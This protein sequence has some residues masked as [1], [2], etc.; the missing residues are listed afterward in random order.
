MLALFDSGEK[1][2]AEKELD[3]A[4]QANP[5]NVI[6]L[7]GAAYWYAAHSEPDRAIELSQQAITAEPRY[8][9]S[10]LALAHAYFAK[11]QP[12]DAEQAL[13]RGR[14][15]GRFPTLEY[16]LALAR[17]KAGL[18]REAV[19]VLRGSFSVE[20][21]KVKVRLGGRVERADASFSELLAPE[22]KASIFEPESTTDPETAAILKALL[23]FDKEVQAPLANEAAIS[24][25]A[26]KFV[27]GDD[28]MKVHRQIYVATTLL[29][30]NVALPKVIELTKSAVDFTDQGLNAPNASAATMASELYDSRMLALSKNEYLHIP[31]V[32]KAMLSAIIRGRIEELAGWALY[33]E[34]QTADAVTRLRR[35]VSVLPP[36]SAWWRSSTWKLGAALQADGKDAESLQYYLKSYKADKPDAAR[37]IVVAAL[38]K[39]VKGNDEGLE[40]EIGPNP[41]AITAAVQF[42]PMSSPSPEAAPTP[43]PRIVSK[44]VRSAKTEVIPEVVPVATPTVE[45][46]TEETKTMTQ[47]TPSRDAA[48]PVVE[49]TTAP[50][51]ELTSEPAI[52]ST[53]EPKI[54]PAAI[55][56]P[57]ASPTPEISST[58]VP[59]EPAAAVPIPTP[60]AQ[61]SPTVM[62]EPTPSPKIEPDP[63]PPPM[64]E[65]SPT[66]STPEAIPSPTPAAEIPSAV[67]SPTPEPSLD[68]KPAEPPKQNPEE[69]KPR[70]G[71]VAKVDTSTIQP[72][73]DQTPIE[74]PSRSSNLSV[75]VTENIPPPTTIKPPSSTRSR[76]STTANSA[77]KKD[78]SINNGPLFEPVIITVPR[79]E[80]QTET[81]VAPRTCTVSVS[82]ERISLAGGGGNIGLL[83]GTGDPADLRALKFYSSSPSDVAVRQES[84]IAGDDR[85]FFVIR[86]L[87]KNTGIYQVTFE[88]PCGKKQVIVNVR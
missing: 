11:N 36:K 67:P 45:P 15:Y 8:V 76:K 50:K 73:G 85:A 33:Q 37:Y 48:A 27:E 39:K 70:S 41:M 71:E 54:E 2:T 14:Q 58:P 18:Y 10:H 82:Q 47:E 57:S 79:R 9:W 25:T 52:K 20:G 81:A 34:G 56:S 87:S 78:T 16:E 62:P 7:A 19:E 42:P 84:R 80:P 86:S 29:D 75:V 72:P 12:L 17:A 6:L 43:T 23:A 77:A 30:K 49:P 26:D 28:A 51:I 13:L 24:S 83:V 61:S 38:Y 64:I 68:K 22:R 5:G 4:L 53:S 69:R 35:A 32:P 66:V 44:A 1:A 40:A 60:E 55:A 3:A 46:K 65:P 59:Q 21:D 63:T 74:S 88:A 31:D